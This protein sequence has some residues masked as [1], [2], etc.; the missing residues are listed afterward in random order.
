MRAPDVGAGQSIV[1]E[2]VAAVVLQAAA[3]VDGLPI[4]ANSR[5]PSVAL[6]L[7]EYKNMFEV[8][9]TSLK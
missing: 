6:F 7:K 4:V 5:R 9:E 3:S 1:G 8:D 2:H